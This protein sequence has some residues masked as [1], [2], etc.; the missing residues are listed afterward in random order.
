MKSH[1][2][3]KSMQFA[4]EPLKKKTREIFK[5]YLSFICYNNIDFPQNIEI[6][7]F[8]GYQLIVAPI[9][10]IQWLWF[11]E[12]Y[13]KKYQIFVSST[14][15]DLIE[16]R[17][18]AINTIMQLGHIPAGMEMFSAT[19]A[20]QLETIK[21]IIDESDYYLIILGGKYGSINKQ[22]GLSYT[23]MEFD[24]AVEQEKRIIAFVH[25]D[26]E[27]LPSFLRENTDRSRKRYERF[28]SKLLSDKLV[29][30]WKNNIDFTQSIATSIS[31]VINQYPSKTCWIHVNQDDI[32]TP[33][34][35]RI[36]T[37]DVFKL[38][39]DTL[40]NVGTYFNDVSNS[41]LKHKFDGNII[42]LEV[43]M[44]GR[45]EVGYLDEFAGCFIRM[46]ETTRDWYQYLTEKFALHFHYKIENYP[47]TVWIEIKT[48]NVELVKEEI[49]LDKP[50]NDVIVQL[51]DTTT[52]LQELHKV[53]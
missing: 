6:K 17:S 24:Y 34:E 44:E 7:P 26:P 41:S 27:N 53:K 39:P 1:K 4:Q 25:E 19:G 13:M 47:Q 50:E 43:N 36:I 15:K 18:I 32:Y 40:K 51:N 48:R 29:K 5:E 2:Q 28:R 30:M 10:K 8:N 23:E 33:I 16:E 52:E 11:G 20:P 31:V 21:P 9:V 3:I 35:K 49:I 22:S 42:E 46:D 45:Q 37:K 14:Y 38:I 12:L